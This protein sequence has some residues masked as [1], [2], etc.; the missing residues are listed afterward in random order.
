MI[1]GLT[2]NGLKSLE[3]YLTDKVCRMCNFQVFLLLKILSANI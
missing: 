1:S 3:E 2:K